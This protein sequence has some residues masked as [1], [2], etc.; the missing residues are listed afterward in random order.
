MIRIFVIE[1]CYSE[2]SLPEYVCK[3]YL[4]NIYPCSR[5]YSSVHVLRILIGILQVERLVSFYWITSVGS[6]TL[7]AV[8]DA[9]G[10]TPLANRK[11]RPTSITKS[12]SS[13]FRLASNVT[14]PS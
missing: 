8:L 9:K 1:V 13:L 11:L 12:S 5:V 3:E 2:F 6:C 4:P 14:V 7:V 10:I